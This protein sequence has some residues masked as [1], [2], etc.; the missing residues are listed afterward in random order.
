MILNEKLLFNYFIRTHTMENT[1]TQQT[2]VD[3]H[4]NNLN[5]RPCFKKIRD[6]RKRIL[7]F[8]Y[9]HLDYK[10]FFFLLF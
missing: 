5:H 2:Y 7:K 6:F 10:M 3:T 1:N 8:N 4:V 9:S